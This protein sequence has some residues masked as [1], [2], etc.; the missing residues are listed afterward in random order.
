ML[1]YSQTRQFRVQGE[2]PRSRLVA[3]CNQIRK[4]NDHCAGHGKVIETSEKSVDRIV[5]AD[6]TS[7]GFVVCGD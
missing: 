2:L 3:L 1:V 6:V 4:R 7:R 5:V